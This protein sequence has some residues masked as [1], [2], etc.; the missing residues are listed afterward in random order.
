M[1]HKTF[2]Y[3]QNKNKENVLK[4]I[5]KQQ[6]RILYLKEKEERITIVIGIFFEEGIYVD[7]LSKEPLFLSCDKLSS[8]TGYPMSKK[9]LRK[10]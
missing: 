6:Y 2:L 10:L 4:K 9:P 5:S 3:V 1:D 8:S 7:V